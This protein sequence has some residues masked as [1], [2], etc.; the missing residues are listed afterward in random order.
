MDDLLKKELLNSKI[1]KDIST[2]FTI[3]NEIALNRILKS[4][5]N[6]D[7]TDQIS[8]LMKFYLNKIENINS[9]DGQIEIVKLD[10]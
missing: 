1:V 7:F 5:L 6:S 10:K 2:E 3:P 4:L 9:T 8:E